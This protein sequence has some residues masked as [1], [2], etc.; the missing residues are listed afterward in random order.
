MSKTQDWVDKKSDED[1]VEFW[2]DQNVKLIS[3]GKKYSIPKTTIIKVQKKNL[4]DPDLCTA[5]G[6]RTPMNSKFCPGCGKELDV[7]DQENKKQ[8]KLI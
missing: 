2:T 3:G 8:K 1:W 6:K 4:F 5:C 7:L